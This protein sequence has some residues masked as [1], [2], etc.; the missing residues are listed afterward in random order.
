MPNTPP[1]RFQYRGWLSRVAE[2]LHRYPD[3]HPIQ[4]ALR[5]Y[6]LGLF[7]S[8]SPP[9]MAFVISSRVRKK[10]LES[11]LRAFRRE[12]SITGFAFAMT[13]AVGGGAALQKILQLS[14]GDLGL[15]T[16]PKFAQRVLYRT[17]NLLQKLK[18]SHKTFLSYTLSSSVAIALLQYP[19]MHSHKWRDRPSA[20]LDLSLVLLVRAIDSIVRS[21]ILSSPSK[22]LTKQEQ[23]EAQRK[24]QK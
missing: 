22:A 21:R 19:T 9:V 6:A 8:L 13:V 1:K 3:D 18:D 20:T 7:L 15:E 5:T 24:R 23:D 16:L 4:I 14:T 2:Y 17:R 10:G 12:L 11:L